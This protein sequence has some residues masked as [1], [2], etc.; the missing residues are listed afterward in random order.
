MDVKFV[1]VQATL[2]THGQRKLVRWYLGK[3]TSLQRKFKKHPTTTLRNYESQIQDTTS[4]LLL[5]RQ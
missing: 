1:V 5:K 3:T 2:Q 4:G